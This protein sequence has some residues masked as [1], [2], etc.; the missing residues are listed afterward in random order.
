MQ[1]SDSSYQPS[2]QVFDR[3]VID[4]DGDVLVQTST[5]EFLISSKVLSLASPVFKAM[6]NSKFLE[7]STIRSAQNPLELSLLDDNPNALA[8]LFHNLHF[9]SEWKSLK[10]G[11]DLL[12]DV[13]QLSDKYDCTT[14]IAAES[15]R[16]LNSL[17]ESDHRPLSVVWKLST[18]AFLMGHINEFSRLTLDL[19][20]NLSAAEL[21][22]TTLNSH[23]PENLKGMSRKSSTSSFHVEF[24]LTLG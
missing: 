7:G 14:S 13:A 12:L 15:G 11:V 9:S 4:E 22:H 3:E 23:L 5:K 20:Y 10:L 18:I 6:F 21:D 17:R 16:W 8:V 24:D 1:H 19:V 2:D